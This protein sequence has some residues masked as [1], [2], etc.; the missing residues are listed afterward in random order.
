MEAVRRTGTARLPIHVAPIRADQVGRLGVPL[1]RGFA[2]D[3]ASLAIVD[4]AGRILPWQATILAR[5]PDRSIKWLLIDVLV[6]AADRE[7]DLFLIDGGAGFGDAAI[8]FD[9]L[10]VRQSNTEIVVGSRRFRFD[11]RQ[12]CSGSL[13]AASVAGNA[14]LADGGVA[15]VLRQR[16][17]TT[18]RTE[19]ASLRVDLAGP[20]RVDILVEGGFAGGA[21]CPLKYRARYTFVA[22]GPTVCCELMIRNPRAARHYGGKWDLGDAGSCRLGDLSLIVPSAAPIE[23]LEWQVDRGVATRRSADPAPWCLYQDS[24]GGANWDSPNHVDAAGKPTV[25][26]RGYEIRAGDARSP[27]V[28]DRGDRAQPVL[29]ATFRQGRIA[30]AVHD[31]WQNFPKALR[32]R[33]DALEIG[34]FP[35]EC[36]AG[37][38][39]QGGEQKRHRLWLDFSP[40]EQPPEIEQATESLHLYADPAW[41][42]ATGAVPGMV[43]EQT[44]AVRAG[45]VARIVDSP[46][47]FFARRELIDEYGWRNFGDL[48]ADHEAVHH[49]GPKPFVSHYNN[50]YDFVLGAGVHALRTGDRRW[51]RLMDDAARHCVD[52]D[53]Y[54]TQED[55]PAF[56]GG[57]FWHSDHYLPASTVTH[58]TYSRNNGAG[59]DYG[60]GPGNEHNY[61]SGL[62][63]HHYMS[64]DAES[65]EAVIG[66]ADWVLAMDDGTATLYGLLDTGAT[67]LASK[68][69]QMSYHGPGRGAGNSINA[70]LDA[71]ATTGRREYM[72]AA[73]ALIRRCIHPND[74]VGA[75][76]LDNPE[77]RWS[78]LVFLQVL[79]KYLDCKRELGETD[80]DFHRARESLLR[81]AD[82][83]LEHEVPYRDVLHKVERPT[84]TWSAQDIRKCHVMH[85]AAMYDDRGRAAAFAERADFFH[86]RCVDD[87]LGFESNDLTRPLVILCVFGH[88]HDFY[89][90]RRVTAGATPDWTHCHDFGIP[91]EFV[92]QAARAAGAFARRLHGAGREIARLLRDRVAGW[93][94]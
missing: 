71:Y 13:A 38:E 69:V 83:M 76:G 81:Y 91:Q 64:G 74:D 21:G 61:T 53:I 17:G 50:Q 33:D 85:L 46:R 57:L 51:W 22:T 39:I 6:P 31:F 32:R 77:H 84:E 42:A 87:L 20:L 41:V 23:H 36:R 12:G 68:T 2:G 56:N 75:R 28:V 66:L 35:G 7:R 16:D 45:Y 67:G 43:V 30:V 70:L 48:Y 78:Y 8:G 80:Y 3:P 72:S 60:G 86:D 4:E 65:R 63:L 44:S 26:F 93:W 1:P 18:L 58:R 52:I 90:Q 14:L 19:P 89:R 47:S 10:V 92:P 37:V 11:L 55:R 59:R 15:L 29:A 34:I 73:E 49:R 88:L 62:L 25:A 5:W 82:W 54:H 40:P 9:P 24:S 79:G 94:H 27:R